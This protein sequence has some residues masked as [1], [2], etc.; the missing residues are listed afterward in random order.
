MLIQYMQFMKAVQESYLGDIPVS[1]FVVH[2][3]GKLVGV[4]IGSSSYNTPKPN[5]LPF[6]G[7]LPQL[8]NTFHAEVAHNPIERNERNNPVYT[9]AVL[10]MA[11]A[12]TE[13]PD[14]PKGASRMIDQLELQLLMM[15]LR[16]ITTLK[17]DA[18]NKISWGYL[19]KILRSDTS[20]ESFLPLTLRNENGEKVLIPPTLFHE[21]QTHFFPWRKNA[22]QVFAELLPTLKLRTLD[23]EKDDGPRDIFHPLGPFL[24]P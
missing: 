15:A 22:N 21:S 17:S 18:M 23:T 11:A 4:K 13:D 16:G 12:E 24:E 1:T 5:G 2:E 20:P 19:S 6:P 3:E 14:L 8:F 9:P 7:P 10:F